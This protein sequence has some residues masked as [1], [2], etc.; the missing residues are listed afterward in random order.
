MGR[1]GLVLLAGLGLVLACGAR[2]R[3]LLP[4]SE[5]AA[6]SSGSGSGGSVLQGACA[7]PLLD[8]APTPMRGYCPTRANQ[9]TMNGPRNPQIA[10]TVR[11]FAIDDPTA[12]LPADVVVDPTGHAFVAVSASPLA[13]AGPNRVVA[14]DPEGN[15]AW[16]LSFQG[17]VAGL[18]LGADGTLWTVEQASQAAVEAGTGAAV[19]HGLSRQGT[20]ARDFVVP[21]AVTPFGTFPVPYDSLAMTSD[22]GFYLQAA[23]GYSGGG[24]LARLAPDGALRWQQP[25]NGEPSWYYAFAGPVMVTPD[26]R[27]VSGEGGGVV[28]FDVNGNEAWS[29]GGSSVAAVDGA[30]RVWTLRVDGNAGSLVTLDATGS[31]LRTTP[32]GSPTITM[33]ACH[34]VLAHDGGVV[35]MLVD[36]APSPGVTKAHVTLVALDA[37]GGTHWTTS[38][39]ASLPY[40]PAATSAHYGVFADASGMLVVTAGS[41]TGVDGASGSVLWTVQPPNAH[42]CLRGAVLGAGGS[43]LATQCD[44]TVFLARDP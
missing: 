33:D 2:T 40:D 4:G 24:G 25:G 35:V 39:D 44:G 16:R 29:A 18:A 8:G 11:P 42:S 41:V 22:G 32:L 10:W 1:R 19:V 30:A 26:D 9:A 43:I 7:A 37:S 28:A 3:L 31:P 13:P 34:L 14:L 5:G 27:V 15:E 23:S 36:E 6:A 21:S 12:F 38:L 17:R 20:A